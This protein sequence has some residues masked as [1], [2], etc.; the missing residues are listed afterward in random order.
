MELIMGVMLAWF[1]AVVV[2]NMWEFFSG[3][4]V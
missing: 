2:L 1:A 4:E 3:A